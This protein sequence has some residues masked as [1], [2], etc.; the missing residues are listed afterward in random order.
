MWKEG[1]KERKLNDY[2]PCD[3]RLVVNK[4]WTGLMFKWKL[5]RTDTLAKDFMIDFNWVSDEIY[6]N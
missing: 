4:T 5:E 2:E 3:D 1:K 6:I